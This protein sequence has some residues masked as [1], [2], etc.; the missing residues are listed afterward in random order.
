MTTPPLPSDEKRTLLRDSVRGFLHQHGPASSAVVDTTPASADGERALWRELAEMGLAK[1]RTE[2][3]EGGLRELLLVM[4]E[5]GRAACPA[6]PLSAAL[7]SLLQLPDNH[8]LLAAMR[9]RA[10]RVDDDQGEGW[11][12]NGQ[13]IWTTT[14]WGDYML[15]AARTHPDAKP[16]HAGLS[17]FV[18]PMDTPGIT[19]KPST[20]MYGGSFANLFYDNVRVPL[21]ASVGQ[22]GAGWKV[23]T[24]AL[25]TKRGFI[26]G[27]IVMKVARLFELLCE[28]LRGT[29]LRDDPLVRDRIGDL[30]AQIEA[31]RQMMM[32]C[33]AQVDGDETPPYDAAAASKVYSSELME[34]FG[35]AALDI[36]GMVGTLGEGSPGAVLRGRVEQNLRHAL[37]WVISIGT[38]DIQR[39][40]IAQRGLGLPR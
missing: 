16:L 4:E 32:H 38:N 6:P 37:M 3:G 17:L 30:A 27:G 11:L 19:I 9:T 15:L 14:Y 13:I 39:S 31:G 28:H 34:G 40:L 33:A 23:L 21:D 7:L 18:V 2:P 24:G 25:A 22:P 36:L 35:E 29:A 8:T 10:V 20:T 26:G 12:I 5:L 1:L